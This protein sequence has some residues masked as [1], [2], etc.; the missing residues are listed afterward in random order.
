MEKTAAT[1]ADPSTTPSAKYPEWPFLLNAVSAGHGAAGGPFGCH[2]PFLVAPGPPRPPTNT[3]RWI[4]V[5][6]G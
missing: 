4:Q 3:F 6:P 2:D 5:K 1:S